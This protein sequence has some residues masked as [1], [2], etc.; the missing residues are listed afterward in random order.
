MSLCKTFY[1]LL[2]MVQFRKSGKHTDMTEKLLSVTSKCSLEG[3]QASSTSFGEKVP[4][5]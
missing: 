1:P 2:S 3:R 5:K 4:I